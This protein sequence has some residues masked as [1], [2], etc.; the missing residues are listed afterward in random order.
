V[1]PP[2][3]RPRGVLAKKRNDPP[4]SPF[5]KGVGGNHRKGFLSSTLRDY[6]KFFRIRFHPWD[7]GNYY[8]V[9]GWKKRYAKDR[10]S[11]LHM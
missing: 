2:R 11:I 10:L 4:F 5:A 3:G 8:L 9:E 7:I 6:F 1:K